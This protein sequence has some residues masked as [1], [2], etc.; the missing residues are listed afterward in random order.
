MISLFISTG[1][2][3]IHPNIKDLIHILHVYPTPHLHYYLF[4]CLLWAKHV[5]LNVKYCGAPIVHA[6][7]ISSPQRYYKGCC[8]TAVE[9]LI[10]KRWQSRK[11]QNRHK[12]HVISTA[13]ALSLSKRA[14]K[15]SYK[16]YWRW[17]WCTLSS[18]WWLIN[19]LLKKLING[20]PSQHQS[21]LTFSLL[22]TPKR[23][24]I[25][26]EVTYALTVSFSATAAFVVEGNPSRS[27]CFVWMSNTELDLLL[28]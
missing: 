17:H 12:C 27:T 13:L 19:L 21:W 7:F 10:S 6:L 15:T 16:L 25:M 26:W 4:H 28:L 23:P 8:A 5:V 22:K 24:L 11:H 1:F 20:K 14:P 3:K 18:H 9:K 2:S